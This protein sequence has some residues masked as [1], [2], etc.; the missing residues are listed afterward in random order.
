M[1]WHRIRCPWQRNLPARA[2]TSSQLLNGK[3]ARSAFL[4]STELHPGLNVVVKPF[5]TADLP[6]L[7]SLG[8]SGSKVSIA[9]FWFFREDAMHLR[10]N[11]RAGRLRTSLLFT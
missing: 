6:R 10:E 9:H 3:R 7:L 1:Y 4:Y 11:M 2:R 8:Y 5:M